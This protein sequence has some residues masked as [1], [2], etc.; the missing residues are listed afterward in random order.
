MAFLEFNG[1]IV[2]PTDIAGIE[3]KRVVVEIPVQVNNPEPKPKKGILAKLMYS[4]TFEKKVK[5]EY[6]VIELK[7]KST[8]QIITKID[9]DTGAVSNRS[10]QTY[11]FYAI[12]GD[13]EFF[14]AMAR[15][16]NKKDV[17][18][19]IGNFYC[20]P[21]M[22]AYSD[23]MKTNVIADPDIDCKEDFV[24]KYIN[25]MPVNKE[26]KDGAEK[27][28]TLQAAINEVKND[29][30]RAEQEGD[31][32]T[33]KKFTCEIVTFTKAAGGRHAPFFTNYTPTLGFGKSN[34]SLAGTITLP[35]DMECCNPGDNA[36]VVIEVNKTIRISKGVRFNINENGKTIGFGTIIDIAE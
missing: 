35:D 25:N 31:M 21:G 29:T 14:E 30:K 28:M 27:R 9:E 4:D 7:V 8:T 13:G 12:C 23:Y 19:K 24:A 36:R 6:T 26:K 17:E 22:L 15:A 1:T 33:G 18:L 20:Y 2:H 10:N 5:L 16:S 32:I 3:E 11:D 34:P